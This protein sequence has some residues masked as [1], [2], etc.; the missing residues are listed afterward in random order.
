MSEKPEK[1]VLTTNSGAPVDDD[2]NTLTAGNPGPALLQ[3]IH[4]LARWAA[5]LS[6]S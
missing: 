6:Y 1:K 3:D 5:K 4:L 2:Q